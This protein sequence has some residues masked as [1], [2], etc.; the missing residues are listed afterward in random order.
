MEMKSAVIVHFPVTHISYGYNRS[1]ACDN[2]H[3]KAVR[4]LLV[5]DTN[6]HVSP[7][8]YFCK[9]MLPVMSTRSTA[10]LVYRRTCA[11]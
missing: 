6:G 10:V 5:E 8:S 4:I 11:P 3:M 2:Y 1:A 9:R 7:G